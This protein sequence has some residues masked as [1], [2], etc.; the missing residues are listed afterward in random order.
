MHG[1]RKRLATVDSIARHNFKQM[2][3]IAYSLALKSSVTNSET[4]RLIEQL[5]RQIDRLSLLLL[6]SVIIK[7]HRILP[8]SDLDPQFVS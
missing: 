1:G 5:Y 4:D 8:C 3:S 7:Y 2:K 6:A